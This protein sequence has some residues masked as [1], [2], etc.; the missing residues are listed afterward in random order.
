MAAELKDTGRSPSVQFVRQDAFA[1]VVMACQNPPKAS[2]TLKEFVARG[3][4][5]RKR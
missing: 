2:S 3:R 5:M 4:E 1:R